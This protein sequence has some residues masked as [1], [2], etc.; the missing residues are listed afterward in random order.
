M[1]FF[2]EPLIKN[3]SKLKVI[4]KENVFPELGKGSLQRMDII[5]FSYFSQNYIYFHPEYENVIADLRYGTLPYDDKSLW[6]IEIDT[7]N[8]ENHVKFLNL[9]KFNN[10]HYKEFWTLLKGDF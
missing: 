7:N 4:N 1:P 6:G 3:G 9:R 2:S 8:K 5:R 10:E